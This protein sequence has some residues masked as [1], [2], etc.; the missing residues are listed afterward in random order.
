MVSLYYPKNAI[1]KGFCHDFGSIMLCSP[2]H[3]AGR[4]FCQALPLTMQNMNQKTASGERAETGNFR[5][6]DIHG[7][8]R[9]YG[10]VA[11][12]HFYRRNDLLPGKRELSGVP[13]QLAGKILCNPCTK[14]PKI[15]A[16]LV[17]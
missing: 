7:P 17:N 16:K 2:L 8:R 11:S 15:S 13:P 12:N 5:H 9:Q 14:P 4:T 3:D 1:C 6:H 10:P